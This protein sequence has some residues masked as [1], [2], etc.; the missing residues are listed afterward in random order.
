[1]ESRQAGKPELSVWSL[2]PLGSLIRVLLTLLLDLGSVSHLQVGLD[3]P[4]GVR[5]AL[6]SAT[7]DWPGWSHPADPI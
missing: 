1:M 6:I 4:R 3:V 7:D 2:G 5:C